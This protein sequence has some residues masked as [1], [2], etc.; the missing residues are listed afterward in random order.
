MNTTIHNSHESA[1][2]T[3]DLLAT[4]FR[5]KKKV[6]LL[7]L[8]ALALGLLVIL[9]FP[10][11]YR[12]EAKLFLQVGRE[13][14]GL[15][16]TATV[17]Q[18]ISMQRNGRNEEVKSA[19]EVLRSRGVISKVVDRLGPDVVL[20]RTEASEDQQPNP[21]SQAAGQVLKTAIALVKSIDPISDREK[22]IIRIE[23]KL[24][25]EA[26][27]DS[28][29]IVVHFTAQTPKLAQTICDAVVNVYQ[30]EHIR[31]NSNQES[32]PFFAIQRDQL[33]EQ[34]VQSLDKLRD[35]KNQL[36]LSSIEE[37][38]ASLEEHFKE[39]GLEKFATEQQ[40]ATAR[41]QVADLQQQL[42]TL[43]PRM[44]TE[45]V[46]VPNEGADL[47]REKLYQLQLKA[48][49]L[50]ARYNDSHPLVQAVE[51]QVREAKTIMDNQSEQRF[52]TTDNVN[53]IHERLS[54]DLK[55]QQSLAAGYESRLVQLQKQEQAVLADLRKVNTFEV[56]VD[57]LQR[58]VQLA[59]TSFFQYAEN[60]EQARIDKELEKERVSNVSVVQQATL[61]EKPASPSKLL[62]A[63][64]TVLLAVGGTALAVLVSEMLNNHL[65]TSEEVEDAL[66]I[67]V[68]AA[69]PN[70][71]VYRR[72]LR[73]PS[74][75][76]PSV[77]RPTAVRR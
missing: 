2:G 19:L 4:L 48:M 53:P 46:S 49:D 77:A 69:I 10:R 17:G 63:L 7:P 3:H 14:V 28:T 47:L 50:H 58:E 61:Q 51:D 20:G 66:G 59:R 23:E 44:I 42:Q 11:S 25:A 24:R 21:F 45:K 18:T 62:V 36:G 70:D 35:A 73:A 31:I 41:A 15:D 5:H 22:A 40:L 75:G 56:Q 72:V 29:V 39:V 34:L 38:R 16:P 32:R 43:P 26:Q 68:L 71:S 67:P 52:E 55:Q 65:R 12:S 57:G 30:Q 60:F 37:R 74:N 27:R 1:Y 76:R 9:Y 6:V 33:R 54:L 8:C 64:A 13:T